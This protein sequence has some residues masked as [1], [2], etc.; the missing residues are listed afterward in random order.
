MLEQKSVH[1]SSK[2]E[3]SQIVGNVD[4]SQL[5]AIQPYTDHA[6]TIIHPPSDL[7]LNQTIGGPGNIA[8]NVTEYKMTD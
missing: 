1:M 7:N 6:H 8:T 3:E 4:T 2:E 5:S